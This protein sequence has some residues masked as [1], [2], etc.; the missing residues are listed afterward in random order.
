MEKK[1]I[2]DLFESSAKRFPSNPF[3]WEKTG[4][5]FE[6]TT[7]AE[8]RDLVYEEGA[9]LISLGVR[10]GDN[11]ALLSEGRN[12]W[13]IGELAMFY[14]G[15][16]NVPLSIKLEEANDLLFR[17]VHADVKYIMVSGQQLKKIRAIKDKLPAVRKIIVLDEQ[18]EYQDREMSLSEICRM[19]K[20]YLG[21]H[22]IEEFLAIG[23]SLGNDDY[24]TITYTSGTT[25]DPKGVILTNRN[26]MA[27]VGDTPAGPLLRPRGRILHLHVEG[28][29]GSYRAGRAYR[30][31]D[32]E[33]YPYQYKGVQA[34]PDTERPRL[35]EELQEEYRARYPSARQERR[36]PFQPSLTDRL[37]L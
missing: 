34:V 27:Y 22:P 36:P 30:Y 26:Y 13:I 4:K 19:G 25:A 7:Y 33:E 20:V 16:T 3:L 21:I 24:A 9:G 10:K 31:G 1:T 18:A 14:A 15:A 5:R 37:Y 29:L 32:L 8:V 6:P 35:G 12:A 23:Q 11:M 2:I 17:L 28:S